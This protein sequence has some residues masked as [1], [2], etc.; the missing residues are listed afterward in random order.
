MRRQKAF[1]LLECLVALL[2][3]S[4]I[5]MVISFVL[6]S[7][8]R[9]A[10]NAVHDEDL[11]WYMFLRELESPVHQFELY[12]DVGAEKNSNTLN[13]HSR[14]SHKYYS[15]AYKDDKFYLKMTHGGSG[16]LLLLDGVT[17]GVNF[18]IDRL[19]DQRV[20]ITAKLCDHIEHTGVVQLYEYTKTE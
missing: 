4:M 19:S 12:P 14:T 1:T 5:V 3:T 17:S 6:H 20:R 15:L 16:Y 9:Q 8:Q 18:R 7:F 13:L 11:K 2:I 10:T